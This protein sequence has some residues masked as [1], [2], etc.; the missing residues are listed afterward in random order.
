LSLRDEQ[1]DAAQDIDGAVAVANG[2]LQVANF[3]HSGFPRATSVIRLQFL[4]EVQFSIG[5]SGFASVRASFDGA[6]PQF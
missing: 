5:N 1:I 6:R 4:S 3:N 2:F